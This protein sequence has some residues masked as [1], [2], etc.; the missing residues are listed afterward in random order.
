LYYQGEA[1]VALAL[2][3]RAYPRPEDEAVMIKLLSHLAGT[4]KLSNQLEIAGRNRDSRTFDH[5]GMLGLHACFDL[6]TDESLKAHGGNETPW[7]KKTLLDIARQ[8]CADELKRVMAT[9][10]P[11]KIG[12]FKGRRGDVNPASIRLEG[13]QAVKQL[14]LRVGARYGQENIDEIHGW[15]KAVDRVHR[16]I[17]ASQYSDAAA[18]AWP[19]QVS[20]SGAIRRGF[21]VWKEG[22]NAEVRID[23]CQHAI[24]A[25]LALY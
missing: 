19:D 1:L 22:R 16:F 23:Y 9:G 6:L 12:S 8:Y 13:V 10:P 11:G 21:D 7:T 4:W 14:L 2:A 25:L 17:L 18:E 3:Q 20:V 5:W 15:D 24:S